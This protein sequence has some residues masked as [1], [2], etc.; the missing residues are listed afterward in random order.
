MT[1][2]LRITGV[3]VQYYFVC[4]R[5]LWF[6]SK[7]IKMEEKVYAVLMLEILG[8]PANHIKKV[9]EE[10]VEKLGNEKNVEITKKKINIRLLFPNIV[11]LDS[12]I[13]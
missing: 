3:Y 1:D 10:I 11:L 6:F 5:K 4:K 12:Y 2:G 8:K 13:F 9:L 7:N